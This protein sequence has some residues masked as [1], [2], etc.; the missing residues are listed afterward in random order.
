MISSHPVYFI[1]TSFTANLF[2]Y[3]HD[4]LTGVYQVIKA[5]NRLGARDK[6]QVTF[7][8]D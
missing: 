5:T 8:L 7:S 4:T 2:H 6:N 1:T 3:I